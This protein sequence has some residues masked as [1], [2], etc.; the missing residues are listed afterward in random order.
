[1]A[2]PRPCA[3]SITPRAKAPIVKRRVGADEDSDAAEPRR[4]V[5]LRRD[6]PD[7]ACR[8]R[9]APATSM[10]ALLADLDVAGRSV[11][12]IS[13]SSSISPFWM[14]RNIGSPAP[15]SHRADARI[16]AADDAVG[17]RRHLGI[18]APPVELAP[19]R[20]D[21]RLLG[22]GRLEAVAGGDEGCASRCPAALSRWS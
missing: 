12:T 11:S 22:L 16:A 9:R 21:L 18:A 19:L 20:F 6:E 13:A 1:M 4:L 3:V 14:M 7:R 10:T 2:R 8:P 17:G 15:L 5:D